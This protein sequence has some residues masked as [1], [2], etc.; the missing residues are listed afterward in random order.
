MDRSHMWQADNKTR[1]KSSHVDWNVGHRKPQDELE[2]CHT[3]AIQIIQ[4][5]QCDQ[6]KKV[7][8]KW[9]GD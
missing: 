9:Q 3:M 4:M 1:H 7:N 6:G 5:P 2:E 8:K